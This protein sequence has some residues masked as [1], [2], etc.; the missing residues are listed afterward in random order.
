M[1]FITTRLLG[2]SGAIILNTIFTTFTRHLT[3]NFFRLKNGTQTR[4]GRITAELFT[5]R[6][7]FQAPEA[8]G[9]RL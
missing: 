5:L 3:P 6:L 4:S 8:R 2:H 9:Q 1:Y 7:E